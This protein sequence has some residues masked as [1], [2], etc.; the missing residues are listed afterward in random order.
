[1]GYDE[2]S[3]HIPDATYDHPGFRRYLQHAGARPVRRHARF[4]TPMVE[5]RVDLR[6]PDIH[7]TGRWDAWT[8]G[9]PLPSAA[10]V[11]E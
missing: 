4:R 1:M 5:I 2:L 3:G 9:P 8:P 11:P 10:E 7:R 6:D